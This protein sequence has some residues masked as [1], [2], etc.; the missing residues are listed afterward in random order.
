MPRGLTNAVKNELATNNFVMAHLVKMDFSGGASYFTDYATSLS[1]QGQA[2]T[3]IGHFVGIDSPSETQELRVNTINI[4]LSGVE[5]SFITIFLTNDWM[6]R[7]V[8][9]DRVVINSAGSIV[10]NPFRIFDGFMTQFQ[11]DEG[12]EKSDVIVAASSHW[13][14]FKKK[15]GRHTNDN[16]QQYYFSGDKGFEYASSIVKDLKR[17]RG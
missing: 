14:D 2:Y 7:G 16:S 15:A 12:G 9:V 11:V 6:N 5:Q 3:P 13:A 1:S 17:G 8:L 4:N 10:Q